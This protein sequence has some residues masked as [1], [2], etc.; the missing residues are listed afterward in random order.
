M[1]YEGLSKS[2][3]ISTYATTQPW[4]DFADSLAYYLLF[5]RLGSDYV[6]VMPEGESFDVMEKLQQ[7]I[8]KQKHEYLENFLKR[9]DIKYP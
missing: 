1:I 9:T 7:S 3:F 2:D 5:Y 6:L 8:F 4:D